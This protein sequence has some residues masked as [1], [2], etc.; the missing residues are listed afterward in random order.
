M[1]S[2]CNENRIFACCLI[3][4]RFAKCE[5]ACLSHVWIREIVGAGTR[6][7][8]SNYAFALVLFVAILRIYLKICKLNEIMHP[9]RFTT[10]MF[11]VR[12]SMF[13]FSFAIFLY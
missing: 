1:Q 12:C 13:V 9:K 7:D 6:E 8:D 4:A 3:I 10:A 11:D 5:L 2:A